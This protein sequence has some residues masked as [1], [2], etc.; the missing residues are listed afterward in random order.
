MYIYIYIYTCTVAEKELWSLVISIYSQLLYRF[1]LLTKTI[2]QSF[3]VLLNLV[4]SIY[5]ESPALQMSRE[6]SHS[7]F[8]PSLQI[9]GRLYPFSGHV[10]DLP[11]KLKTKLHGLSPRANYTDR[12]TAACRRNDCQLLRLEGATWSAWRSPTAV[13]SL[14]FT[15]MGRKSGF[16][17]GNLFGPEIAF[18]NTIRWC[19]SRI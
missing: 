13:F 10:F 7:H 9:G 18:C 16:C 1:I 12:A 2:G 6:C 3:Q 15:P 14:R 8:N 4:N 11:L 17:E 5:I 19:T